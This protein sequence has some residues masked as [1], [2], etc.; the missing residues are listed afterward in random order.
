[1]VG[2]FVPSGLVAAGRHSLAAWGFGFAGLEP[3]DVLGGGAGDLADELVV[4][5]DAPGAASFFRF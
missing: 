3:G 2:T 5:V 4:V 1:V